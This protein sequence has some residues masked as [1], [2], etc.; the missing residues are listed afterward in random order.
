MQ[1]QGAKISVDIIEIGKLL[2]Y[3]RWSHGISPSGWKSIKRTK[4]L[5]KSP[6]TAPQGEGT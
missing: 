4:I 3:K 5:L 2:Y 6:T 1:G